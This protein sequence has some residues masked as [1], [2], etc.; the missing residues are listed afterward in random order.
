MG[1]RLQY[2]Y[3]F[4]C[5]NCKIRTSQSTFDGKCINCGNVV[6]DVAARSQLSPAIYVAIAALG[7]FLLYMVGK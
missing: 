3:P 6:N 7:S 2:E 4:T 1:V 5:P